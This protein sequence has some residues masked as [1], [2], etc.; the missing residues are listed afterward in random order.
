M[1]V[2]VALYTRVS[3]EDQA[4]EGFSLE[5]QLDRLRHYAKA[6]GMVV[7][8]EFVDEGQSGRTAS[9]PAY[10]RMMDAIDSWDTLLVLKMDRIH[11]N[12]Q[13][14]MAMMNLLRKKG[15]E[16]A[17]VMESLDT[18]TAIGRFVMDII[19]RIAQLESDQTGERTYFVMEDLAKKG[20]GNLGRR[21]P[22]GYEYDAAKDLQVVDAEATVVKDIFAWFVAGTGKQEIADRLNRRKT[23]T[24][25]GK[26]WTIHNVTGIL[27]NPVYVGVFGWEGHLQ[28]GS[29]QALVDLPSF[30]VVQRRIA[31]S[32]P[33]RR[34]YEVEA[35]QRASPGAAT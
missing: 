33:K 24:R 16:F 30:E 1:A 13:N 29:H 21:A 34:V 26:R 17:S 28:V 22:F 23:S 10:K 35:I 27:T 19:Q 12:M 25:A 14:F 20:A 18:S 15:K 8:D 11:R 5:A 4:K 7:V 9:R 32:S 6:Q 31:A 3:T 2:R